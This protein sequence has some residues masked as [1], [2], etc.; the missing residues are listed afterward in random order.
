M[1]PIMPIRFLL[2]IGLLVISAS[3]IIKRFVTI[4]DFANGLIYGVGFGIIILS[5]IYKSRS[6]Q[7]A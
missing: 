1:K 5:I 6:K 2:P 4:P 7:A 3:F